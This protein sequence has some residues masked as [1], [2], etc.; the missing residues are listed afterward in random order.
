MSEGKKFLVV[1]ESIL[2]L[3]YKVLCANTYPS[4]RMW[5]MGLVK[6]T[7]ILQSFPRGIFARFICEDV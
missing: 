1:Y 3:S 6:F 2:T 7:K 4:C 5:T